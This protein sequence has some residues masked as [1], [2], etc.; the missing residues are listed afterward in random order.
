MKGRL[1]KSRYRDSSRLK[2]SFKSKQRESSFAF[3][4]IQIWNSAPPEVTTAESETKARSAIRK[5]LP[6]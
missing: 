4:S 5:S 2:I 6:I 3:S 1:L